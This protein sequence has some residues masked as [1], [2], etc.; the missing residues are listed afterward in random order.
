[1]VDLV[2]FDDVAA[3]ELPAVLDQGRA[4][5]LAAR[6]NFE[7]VKLRD[8]AERLRLLGQ[9]LE[10]RDI[11]TLASVL[12]R[13]VERAWV[14]ANP[15]PVGGRPQKTCISDMPVFTKGQR[16]AMR[17]AA[18]LCDDDY[19]ELVAEAITEQQPLTRSRVIDA[20]KP[21][22][23]VS[24]NTGQPEWYTPA[25]I[26]EAARQV[27]GRI[28]LAWKHCGCTICKEIGIEVVLFRGAERNRRRGFHNLA[29]FCQRL[30]RELGAESRSQN[31]T[32]HV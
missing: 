32:C 5:I 10:R 8:D 22:P 21:K 30:G 7:R 4:M 1:M 20:T 18:G 31:E 29:V 12:I 2:R 14:Q 25:A 15:P 24:H 17:A 23:H 11:E 28:D 13:D 6:D 3:L 9:A 16:Q 19:D 26:I 27:L